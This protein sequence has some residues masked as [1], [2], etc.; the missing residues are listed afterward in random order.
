MTELVSS[1]NE[2]ARLM[3]QQLGQELRGAH[4]G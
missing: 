3:L 2:I 1:G 4:I